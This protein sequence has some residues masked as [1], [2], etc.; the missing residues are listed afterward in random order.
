MHENDSPLLLG[1]EE[2]LTELEARV[3]R[4][5]SGEV[6]LEEALALFEE[7]VGLARTCHEQLQE[8]ERRVASLSR[9]PD[10]IE[11]EPLTEPEDKL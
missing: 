4:L 11:E 9:G 2:A 3:R 7:G 6:G 1:F 8:A 10:G 5:E